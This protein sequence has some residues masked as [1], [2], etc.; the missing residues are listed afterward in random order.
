MVCYTG[1]ES[2][3]QRR[4]GASPQRNSEVLFP[5]AS[6]GLGSVREA[7]RACYHPTRFSGPIHLLCIYLS[8]PEYAIQSAGGGRAEQRSRQKV[9]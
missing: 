8:T 7:L 5:A 9:T 2:E 3:T 4:T 6:S 1:E